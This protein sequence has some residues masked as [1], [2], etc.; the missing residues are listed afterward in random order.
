M[1]RL[2]RVAGLK[3]ISAL[4]SAGFVVARTR[5]SHH[6]LK[7]SD[8][9]RTVVSVHGKEIIRPTLLRKILRDCDMTA[10]EFEGLL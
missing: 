2:P 1:T 3:I 9:K 4:E 8:G 6:I 7:H 5:G 10:E